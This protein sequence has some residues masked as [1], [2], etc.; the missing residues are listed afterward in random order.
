MK[1]I[2]ALGLALALVLGLGVTAY[3]STCDGDVSDIMTGVFNAF[4]RNSEEKQNMLDKKLESGQISQDEYDEINDK[5]ENGCPINSQ[6]GRKGLGK[7]PVQ[8]DEN[9]I[10]ELKDLTTDEKLN[11]IDDKLANE[12]I[13][14]DEHDKLVN[15]TENGC[16]FDPAQDG[17][18]LSRGP[19]QVDENVINELK[20]L[21]K[22]EKLNLIEDK[23]AN[24]EI[25]QDEHD[26]LVNMTE[27]GCTFDPAKDGKKL[28][29]FQN[30][31]GNNVIN[32]IKDL[33]TEEQLDVVEDKLANNEI[34]QECYDKL[35]SI[36]Q[37]GCALNT[38]S[39][40]LN[41]SVDS[42][43][44]LNTISAGLNQCNNNSLNNGCTN[45]IFS[46]GL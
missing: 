21:E 43:S 11:L 12:E 39:G 42:G 3:A 22:D 5:I 8:V 33:T 31:A 37:N 28:R 35:V 18:K 14:Q 25:T 2:I 17:K 19:V 24:E 34:V 30:Q 6:K 7:G 46:I 1:K 4:G 20:D 29:K 44:I 26:K 40:G 41:N 23:L 27:N 13:T 10:N 38:I 15:M 32:E 16:T 9:V 36:I 45:G